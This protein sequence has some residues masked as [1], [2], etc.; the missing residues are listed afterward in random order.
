MTKQKKLEE[1]ID[2]LEKQVR[3][4]Q[5]RPVY[6]PVFPPSNPPAYAP[7]INIPWQ[8]LH[9]YTCGTSSQSNQNTMKDIQIFN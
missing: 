4:L 6:V 2:E 3:E 8:P 1:R 5:V 9:P 7:A